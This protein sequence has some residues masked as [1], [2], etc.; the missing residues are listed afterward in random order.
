MIDD[1]KPYPAMK[2]SGVPW[3]GAIAAHWEVRRNGRLFAQRNEMGFAGL[4][5]ASGGGRRNPRR[6]R[7]ATNER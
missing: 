6:A 3:L 5:A 7:R 4:I 2:N 1:L